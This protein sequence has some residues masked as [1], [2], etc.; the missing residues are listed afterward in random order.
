VGSAP[1]TL[2]GA[3]VSGTHYSLVTSATFPITLGQNAVRTFSVRFAPTA[4]CDPCAGVFS[5][6]SNDPDSPSL[7]VPLTGIGVTPP[8]IDTSPDT[9]RAAL[10]TTLGPTAIQ[11]NRMLLIHNSGGSD[12][13]WSAG[14]LREIPPAPVATEVEEIKEGPFVAGEPT[15]AASGGPDAFGYR[16]ADSDDPNG[17]PFEWI[18]ITGI[19]TPIDLPSTGDDQ[20]VAGIPIGFPFPFYDGVFE[21]INVCTN[22]W[23]SFTSTRTNL[24][25]VSLP[26]AGST[27]PENLLAAFWDDLDPDTLE[28]KIWYWGDGTK[29][30]VSY[31][32]VPRFLSGGPYTFQVI[33]YP[34]G[35]IDY[36][37]LDMQGTR[38][39]EATIGIQNA[40]KD[41]GLQVVYN[42]AYVKNNLRVRFT[43]PLGWLSLSPRT[44]VTEAG[45]TDTVWVGF[46]ADGLADGDYSGVVRVA[47]NDLDEPLDYT[48]VALHVGVEPAQ[49][50]VHPSTLN[51]ASHGRWLLASVW[52]PEDLSAR[53]IVHSSVLLQ[54][55][56]PVALHLPIC[57]ID[58]F[59]LYM[60]DRQDLLELLP[61]GNKVPVEVIG[62]VDDQTWF[63]GWDSVRVLRPKVR[64]GG[65]WHAGTPGA[66]MP[67]QLVSQTIAP[68][69]LIDPDGGTATRFE[70]WYSPDAGENWLPVDTLITDRAFLWTVPEDATDQALLEVVAW[71]DEGI[72][73]SRTTNLFAIINGTADADGPPLP[74][75]F[76]LRFAG[77]NPASRATLEFGLPAQGPVSVRVFDVRGALVRE[78]A[79]GTFEA[80][81]HRV[82]WDGTGTGASPAQP[83]V[84]FVQANANGQR[85]LLRFVLLK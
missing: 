16:W 36:Q 30:V 47:S 39:N 38:L 44:G 63:Q 4:A 45:A 77:R 1:L 60:F 14:V 49:L 50:Y 83:G 55:Q 48:P 42:A 24:S 2:T 62:R 10:A 79:S 52:P 15:T 35:T 9:V 7:A 53:K 70:L 5:V 41:I 69:E 19:G 27:N 22:G 57:F 29:F 75:R 51:R 6:A 66:S 34:N 82:T 13:N 26:N 73:G 40:T 25:N 74:E 76:T 84:Y 31:V 71:D 58:R 18:D 3:S 46:S 11:G 80:G 81:W 17:V 32:N 20:N 59:A 72:M 61:D 65:T 23:L 56:V 85:T 28:N 12:L 78:L 54:R 8:E 68:L 64:C 37:Y 67:E 43:N 21:T 33:L